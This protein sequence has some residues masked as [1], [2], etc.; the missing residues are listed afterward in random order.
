MI[1]FFQSTEN[2]EILAVLTALL[3][4]AQVINPQNEQ[5]LYLSSTALGSCN[6]IFKFPL[7]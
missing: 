2:N 4:K 3:K 1:F 5:Q 6:V 7:R